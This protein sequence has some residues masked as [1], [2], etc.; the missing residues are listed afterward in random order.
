VSILAT[1]I[2]ALG[3]VFQ[4]DRAKNLVVSLTTEMT[5]QELAPK[6]GVTGKALAREFDLPLNVSKKNPV[7]N[8]GVTQER[9]ERVAAHL[10][11]HQATTLKYY[12]FAALVLWGLVLLCRLGRPDGSPVSE[13]KTWHPPLQP[14]GA[15]Q[16]RYE[17]SSSG[18]SGASGQCPCCSGR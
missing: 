1:G 12:V 10:R 7:G 6:L 11:S 18:V 5:I 17:M 8:L 13:R 3:W 14:L 9:L 16:A 2:V 15:P 4:P